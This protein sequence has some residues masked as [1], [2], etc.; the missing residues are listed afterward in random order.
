MALSDA[1]LS[2]GGLLRDVSLHHYALRP[3]LLDLTLHLC[4]LPSGGLT[5]MM[6]DQTRSILGG[7]N[8]GRPPNS[9]SRPGDHDDLAH[10]QLERH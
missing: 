10:E 3:E 2:T 1:H 9:S 5:E 6:E 8:S 7:C 4:H